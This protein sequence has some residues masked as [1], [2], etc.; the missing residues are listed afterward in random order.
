M[1]AELSTLAG[2]DQTNP[3]RA[4]DG[5]PPITRVTLHDEVLTR[6]RDM[7]IEGK[8]PPGSRINEV[9]VGAMLGVS[10]TPLR[11][12]IKTLV[13]E[14]LVEII[15]AKGAVVRSFDAKAIR[16]IL[17]VIKS[18]E[19]TAARLVCRNAPDADIAA[20]QA[21][22]AE[23][24]HLYS[25]GDRLAYFKLNQKIHSGLAQASGNPVLAQTHEQLQSRI[26]RIRFIGNEEPGRWA[27]AVAE[28]EE[29]MKA[30][31]ARD[32]E[33]LARILG[34]HLDHTLERVRHA[35]EA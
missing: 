31:A 30:L 29:M 1:P 17:E 2:T 6:V 28:H 8:L 34:E 14:G 5:L 21:T 19:Q 33:W 13:S 3:P 26:K 35:V 11:E 20:L 32:G 27:G 12:A 23:M 9:Q 25:T 4:P 7:I 24:M 22:H 16:D 10:R 18:L 15:P